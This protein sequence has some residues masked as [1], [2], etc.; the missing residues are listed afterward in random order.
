MYKSERKKGEESMGEGDGKRQNNDISA[1]FRG[2]YDLILINYDG[3]VAIFALS[4][5]AICVCVFFAGCRTKES[6]N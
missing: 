1:I 2:K 4:G 6:E 3:Y 5:F